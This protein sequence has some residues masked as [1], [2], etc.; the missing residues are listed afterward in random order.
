MQEARSFIVSGAASGIG[1]HMARVLAGAGHCLLLVD[2]DSD[3]LQRLRAEP[4]FADETRIA[5]RVLDVRDVAGWESAVAEAVERYGRLDVMLNIAGYLL[6]GYVHEVD[7]DVLD[8][9]VDINAKGVMY[10]TRAAARRMIEQGGGHIVN[11]AS[12]AGISPVPGLAAYAASKHAVR[13]FTLSVAHELRPHGIDVSVVCPDAVETPMLELQV[14]YEEAA[15][16]FGAGRGLTL[17]EVERALLE[18]LERRPLERVIAV[19]RSSRGVGAKL[20]GAFPAASGRVL[21]WLRAQ[22]RKAQRRRGSR[23]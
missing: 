9:H 19:P 22:G 23:G 6:P 20:G 2:I 15:L 1:R 12:I 18:V 8:R 10:A 5:T 7:V 21:G 13:G 3:G 4:A 17:R 16:T 11:V 14:G